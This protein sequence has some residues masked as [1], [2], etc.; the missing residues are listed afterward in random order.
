MEKWIKP[1]VSVTSVEKKINKPFHPETESNFINHDS[2]NDDNNENT[3]E[4]VQSEKNIV[5]SD[6]D[7]DENI[8][9]PESG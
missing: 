5:P 8:T 1:G 6:M 3:M 7:V 4:V 2:D 9:A